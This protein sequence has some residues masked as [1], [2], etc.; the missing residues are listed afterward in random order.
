[1]NKTKKAYADYYKGLETPIGGYDR[2]LWVD[3]TLLSNQFGKTI[4]DVG[5]GEGTLLSMLKAK[6]NKVFGIDASEAGR[7]A[8]QKKDIDCRVVDISTEK[9]PYNDD[10][11]DIVLCLE[12]LEHIENPHNCIWEIKRVLKEKGLFIVSIPNS[13]I[14][15]P[16]VYPGLFELKNF[17]TFLQL[18]S[19]EIQKI[20]GWGQA[21]MLNKA[22]R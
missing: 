3:S 18:N 4:L 15:H 9:F 7:T 21:A 12:T 6:Q 13:K 20:I 11:F 1:M 16:Y 2:F 22:A 5:C 19:F 14:L 17:K 10:I 8:S